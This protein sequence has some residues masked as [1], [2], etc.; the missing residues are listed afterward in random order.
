MKLVLLG[1]PGSG[2]GTQ[3]E[4]IAKN[5]GI[6][7]LSTGEILRSA[8]KNGTPL[9]KKAEV[10]MNKGE[11][12]AN[13]LV[14]DLMSARIDEP[15]CNKGY[16]LDGFPRTIEQAKGL[17]DLLTKK[18]VALD[19]VINID[20]SD[21]EVIKRLSGRRMCS[22][23]GAIF[24]VA[25]SPSS[26]GAIC[27]KCGGELYQRDDDKETTILNRMKVYKEKTKALIDFYKKELKNIDGSKNPAD[28]FKDIC[29]LIDK[30]V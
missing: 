16:I 3:G 17:A 25:F 1:A 8:I 24:H 15:D 28:V 27:D 29:S 12:V 22:K 2:K 10:F 5:Y 20:V 4:R 7:Q 11:L 23:C 14:L 6:P 21:D 9:G 19:A 30:V 13:E 26:K 18:G